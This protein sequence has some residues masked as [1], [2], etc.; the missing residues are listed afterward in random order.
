MRSATDFLPWYIRQ[1]MNLVTTGSPNFASGRTCRLTA[2]RRRDMARPS[3]S[4]LLR[5]LGAVFGPALAAGLDALGVEGTADDVR[6]HA[7]QVLDAPP[8]GAPD[9]VFLHILAPA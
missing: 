8:A 7:P 5:P 6:A 1:F 3:P 4:Y 9:P 2:A